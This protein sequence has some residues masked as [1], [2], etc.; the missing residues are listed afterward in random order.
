VAHTSTWDGTRDDDP[1]QPDDRRPR[2]RRR[3]PGVL[4]VLLLA[5]G[6]GTAGVYLGRQIS[7]S[8]ASVSDHLRDG[9]ALDGPAVDP[10]AATYRAYARTRLDSTGQQFDCLDNL[11]TSESGWRPTA[12]NPDSTAYGIAQFLD[13]TWVLMAVGKTSDPYGQIDAGLRYI[14][15]RYGTPC[16]AWDFWL[17]N[18]WY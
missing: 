7:R 11:W 10:A 13:Q 3:W 17:E 15:E 12:Q 4:L 8:A 18:H 6:L 1:V 14:D 5:A 16:D 2:R 9:L